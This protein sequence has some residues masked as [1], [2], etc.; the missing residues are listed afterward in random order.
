M[1]AFKLQDKC[2]HAI[3]LISRELAGIKKELKAATGKAEDDEHYK[4]I[5]NLKEEVNL[6]FT[7]TNE[8]E[9]RKIAHRNFSFATNN[10]KC[11]E[12]IIQLYDD[13]VPV[14]RQMSNLIQRKRSQHMQKAYEKIM[15]IVFKVRIVEDKRRKTLAVEAKFN[16]S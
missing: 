13:L 16:Q 11:L 7:I 5:N 15:D 4:E 3:T 2:L 12:A 8:I 14:A 10:V 6:L 1:I 9:K